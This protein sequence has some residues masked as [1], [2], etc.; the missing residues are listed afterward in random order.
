MKVLITRPLSQ[1]RKTQL[2]LAQA[3]HQADCYPFISVQPLPIC[4]PSTTWQSILLT[5][6]NALAA[7]TT[8]PANAPFQ[9]HVVG[10]KTAE[11]LRQLDSRWHVATYA[12]TARDL[13]EHLKQVP[14]PHTFL[15]VRGSTI[16]F[17]F[18]DNLASLGFQC[19]EV[20]AYQTTSAPSQPTALTTALRQGQ[21]DWILV[22]SGQTA[23]ALAA[24]IRKHN[25]KESM[26]KLKI[27]AI[28]E[29]VANSIEEIGCKAIYI[30]KKPDE[31]HLVALLNEG[32]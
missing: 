22:Y 29:S 24:F 28:S 8:Y 30:A 26:E 21:Y 16:R 18:A 14:K 27:A 7:L 25:L 5:S 3:G 4:W 13:F 12:P 1:A 31:A 17:D 32:L 19:L 15:Y 2:V 10:A 9:A 20:P 6:Q 11:R 23:A